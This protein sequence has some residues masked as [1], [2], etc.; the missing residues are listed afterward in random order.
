MIRQRQFLTDVL[1]EAK[2]N[3]RKQKLLYASAD[4]INALSQ[5]VMNTFHAS[6]KHHHSNIKTSSQIFPSYCQLQKSFLRT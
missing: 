3:R 2:V 1:R 6:W 4:Q 5:L